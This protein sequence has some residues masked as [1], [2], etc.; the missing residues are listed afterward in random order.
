MLKELT[1]KPTTTTKKHSVV[2]A[3]IQTRTENYTGTWTAHTTVRIQSIFHGGGNIWVEM[4]GQVGVSQ[5]KKG[6]PSRK[7]EPGWLFPVL[8]LTLAR[9]H[10]LGISH[11]EYS[12]GI[13]KLQ[14]HCVR[15]SSLCCLS[16]SGGCRISEVERCS[17]HLCISRAPGTECATEQAQQQMLTKQ[18]NEEHV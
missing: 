3:V 11:N 17:F 15:H 16:R 18:I 9:Q 13:P 6:K 4:K 2:P 12:F 5:R 8:F 14:F 1:D 10:L 7:K